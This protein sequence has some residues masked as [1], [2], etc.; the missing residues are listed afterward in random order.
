LKERRGRIAL[1]Y[2]DIEEVEMKRKP[3]FLQ[4]PKITLKTAGKDYWFR[5]LQGD[6]FDSAVEMVRSILPDKVKVS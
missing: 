5:I 1:P 3:G 6:A 4:A 2:S